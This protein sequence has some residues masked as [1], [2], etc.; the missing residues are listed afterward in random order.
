[1]VRY[2]D[3]VDPEAARRARRRYSCFDHFGGDEQAYGLAARFS[4]SASCR[5]E[6]VAQLVELQRRAYEYAHRDGQIAA[7]D[8]FSAEQ[9]A[10]LVR[11]AEEYYRAMFHGRVNT[12][13][14]RDRHMA[15]TLQAL[16]AHLDQRFGNARI[17]V[18]AHNSHLGNARATDRARYGEF[19]LGQ[20]V[21]ERYADAALVGFTTYR[22]TVTAASDWGAPYETKRVRPA[23][24]E[25]HEALFHE[26]GI[27]RF[28]LTF[29]G[30]ERLSAEFRTERLERAIGVIYRPETERASHYFQARMAD[31]F[32]AVLHFD[33]TMAI[34]PLPHVEEEQ[35]DEVPETYPAGV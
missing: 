3:R 5:E 34:E 18:W 20:L 24:P 6:V 13:N 12:W 17:V 27:P 4:L 19:N 10:R 33:E 31:Q 11:N 23:L 7:D 14:L 15:E 8:F 28:L 22:G 1:V 9:N 30:D 21:R 26:C 2:L 25:S 35:T 29:A 32:D 16:A